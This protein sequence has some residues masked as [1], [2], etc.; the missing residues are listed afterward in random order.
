MTAMTVFSLPHL[1][2][3]PFDLNLPPPMTMDG[4]MTTMIA[5]SFFFIYFIEM[6]FMC[7]F[8]SSI[9]LSLENYIYDDDDEQKGRKKKEPKKKRKK[10]GYEKFYDKSLYFVRL[11]VD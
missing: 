1:E 11:C 4:A 5:S 7:S 8:S 3:F 9:R 6:F 2:F 10:T